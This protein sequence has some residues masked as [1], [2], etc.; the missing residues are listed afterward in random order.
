MSTSVCFSQKICRIDKTRHLDGAPYCLEEVYTIAWWRMRHMLN[1]GRQ[2]VR[3]RQ[4][5][6]DNRRQ[7]FVS[8]YV[9]LLRILQLKLILCARMW[10]RS[11]HRDI[12][13]FLEK[14]RR[15]D[16]CRCMRTCQLRVRVSTCIVV[17]VSQGMLVSTKLA[18]QGEKMRGRPATISEM[19]A[20]IAKAAESA[21]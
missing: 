18:T 21:S 12:G 3:R 17:L 4:G 11:A 16:W 20:Y 13:I 6:R 10:T 19:S 1:R 2:V 9:H 14:A 8:R 7:F 15:H 5:S